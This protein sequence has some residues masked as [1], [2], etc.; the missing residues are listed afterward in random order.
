MSTSRVTRAVTAFIDSAAI[1][2]AANDNATPADMVE[3]LAR[4]LA[5]RPAGDAGSDRDSP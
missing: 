4:T 1:V 5:E 3:A 2:A